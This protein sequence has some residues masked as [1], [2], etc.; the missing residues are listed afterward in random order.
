MIITT[1]GYNIPHVLFESNITPGT[2]IEVGSIEDFDILYDMCVN[3]G[4][5]II[6]AK[7]SNNKMIG[8]MFAHCDGSGIEFT[9]V[10]N[11]YNVPQFISAYAEIS[12]DVF[13]CTVTVVSL[14]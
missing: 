9:T 4:I 5:A 13:V 6:E 7:I 11:Q 2:A 12:D 1:N 8:T 3:A 14:S 10:T